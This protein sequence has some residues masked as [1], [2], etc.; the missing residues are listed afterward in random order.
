MSFIFK[1]SRLIAGII[2]ASMLFSSV[3]TAT[4]LA[5]NDENDDVDVIGTSSFEVVVDEDLEPSESEETVIDENV[6]SIPSDETE[7]TEVVV[8]P[9]EE[10][11]IET[12]E[13]TEPTEETTVEEPTTE[14]TTVVE[15]TS[16]TTVE[17][18]EETTETSV[19]PTETS[20]P[21]APS[22]FDLVKCVTMDQFVDMLKDLSD[23]RRVIVE[24][25]D[26]IEVE[27]ASALYFEGVYV[28][29]FTDE[30]SY[31]DAIAYFEA[32]G[33]TYA[34][35]G[36]MTVNGNVSYNAFKA[37]N[38]NGKKVAIIDTGS[39]N[40]NEY[41]SVIG[42][43]TSDDNGHGTAMSN[44]VAES[45]AY[46]ISIKALGSNGKGQVSD[47][48]VAL[49]LAKDLGVDYVLLSM[50]LRDLGNYDA[51]KSIVS[52]IIANGTTVVA[53]AGNNNRDASLYIPANISGV[54]TVG[55][56]NEDLTKN[57]YS[58]YGSVVDF[59][60]VASSTSEAAA[61]YIALEGTDAVYTEYKTEADITPTPETTVTPIP[62]G[63]D[64]ITFSDGTVLREIKTDE[65]YTYEVISMGSEFETTAL[66]V[67]KLGPGGLAGYENEWNK[68]VT[69]PSNVT[70]G[71][72]G[73]GTDTGTATMNHVSGGLGYASN[74]RS[75]S[76]SAYKLDSFIT[77]WLY[78]E[79]TCHRVSSSD[80]DIYKSQH[81]FSISDGAAV[82]YTANWTVS[83]S[84]NTTTITWT[85]YFYTSDTLST[86]NWTRVP[87]MG[88][89]PG[90]N[91]PNS[92]S[93]RYSVYG[94]TS[95]VPGN[96]NIRSVKFT[97]RGPGIDGEI[98]LFTDTYNA[99]TSTYTFNNAKKQQVLDA[100]SSR[101]RSAANIGEYTG[102]K[103]YVL[104]AVTSSGDWYI[105]DGLDGFI[106]SVYVY[107]HYWHTNQ[108]QVYIGAIYSDITRAPVTGDMMSITVTG[109]NGEA[110]SGCNFEL[111]SGYGTGRT[112]SGNGV[113]YPKDAT[114][115]G[116]KYTFSGSD[117][118]L[119]WYYLSDTSGKVTDTYWICLFDNGGSTAW[120]S[121]YKNGY[122]DKDIVSQGA[123][124]PYTYNAS[125]TYINATAASARSTT[126]HDVTL[127]G[128][129][130]SNI[131]FC[132]ERNMPFTNTTLS[133]YTWTNYYNSNATNATLASILGVNSANISAIDF[134]K[135][136]YAYSGNWQNT[137]GAIGSVSKPNRTFSQDE[138]QNYVW[139][140][141]NN[142]KTSGYYTIPT[143]ETKENNKGTTA[144]PFTLKYG[145]TTVTNSTPVEFN[146][147]QSGDTILRITTGNSNFNSNNYMVYTS[148]NGSTNNNITA[149]IDGANRIVITIP[150]NT[151]LDEI[152]GTTINIASK[153]YI[154]TNGSPATAQEY[155]AISYASNST[156][157]NR[158]TAYY[159]RELNGYNTSYSF[160]LN[161]NSHLQAIKASS[162]T[163]MSNTGRCYDFAGTVYT[164]YGSYN[165]ALNRTGGL[166]TLEF[167]SDGTMK[168]DAK[169][170]TQ[171]NR[172]YYLRERT[173]GSGYLI[174][175]HIY[176][177]NIGANPASNMV[178]NQYD[179]NR[180]MTKSNWATLV[181]E[182]GLYTITL[183]DTPTNDP[184]NISFRK[185]DENGQIV[186]TNPYQGARFYIEYYDEDIA[187][188]T[189][190]G[191]RTPR[192]KL[193]FTVNASSININ[194][195]F[196]KNSCTLV[197]G[198]NVFSNLNG[199]DLPLGTY[200]IYE[201]SA[202]T[203]YEVSNQ[204]LRYRIYQPSN[205]AMA[206]TVNTIEGT[207][208]ART[209]W[210]LSGDSAT[211]REAPVI[212]YFRLN[213]SM[214]D[215]NILE[216][217]VSKFNYEL[218]NKDTG[219]LIATGV[220][221]ETI[222][223][224]PNPNGTV[225]WQ[226]KQHIKDINTFDDLYNTW[227]S[228]IQLA[229]YN[230]NGSKINYEVREIIPAGSLNYANHSNIQYKYTTPTG[231]TRV[232]DTLFTLTVQMNENSTASAPY[233]ENMENNVEYSGFAISKSIPDQ[234]AFDKRTV[235][236]NVYEVSS[237]TLIATG[238]TDA[239]GNVTFTRT[240]ST[241]LG[242]T[243]GADS[244]V[245]SLNGINFLPYGTYRIE[246]YWDKHYLNTLDSDTLE[247]I[248]ILDQNLSA[249]WT[250][251]EDAT[252]VYYSFDIT[253]NTDKHIEPAGDITGKTEVVNEEISGWFKLQKQTQDVGDNA[254][255]YFEI[256]YINPDNGSKLLVA[257][258]TATTTNAAGTFT[259]VFTDY[260]G[261]KRANNTEILLPKGQYEIREIEPKTYYVRRDGS[262]SE[263]A[264]TYV[265]PKSGN[266]NWNIAWKDTAHTEVN[267]FYRNVNI[268]NEEVTVLTATA[269]NA[270]VEAQLSIYKEYTASVE[271]VPEVDFEFEIYYRGNGTSAQ[272]VGNFD[273]K[274][275]VEK[276]TVNCTDGSGASD[277]V[278][279][280]PEG[281]YEI[282][283]V[284]ATNWTIGWRGKGEVT[285]NNTK[286][287][288]VTSNGRTV[289]HPQFD[290]R[291]NNFGFYIKDAVVANNTVSVQIEI[292]KL[293]RWTH[294]VVRTA[295]LHPENIH[296][297]FALYNDG[298]NNEI[299]DADEM[300][301]YIASEDANE[302]G[303]VVFKNVSFGHYIIRETKTINGY[304]LTAV[305]IPVAVLTPDNIVFGEATPDTTPRNQ[306]Y[307]VPVEITKLDG[308]TN[309]PLSGAEF[310]IYVD[311]NE[312][313]KY[314]AGTDVRATA[315]VDENNDG[316][317]DQNEITTCV[318]TED[319]AKKGTYRSNGQ[320]HFND[321]YPEFGNQYILREVNAPANYFFVDPDT[322]DYTGENTEI[323]FV[324][325]AADTTAANFKVVPVEKTIKNVTG[326]V[327][328]YKKTEDGSFLSGCVFKV[329]T[330]EACTNEFATL[331]EDATNKCYYYKG[332]GLNTY[333]LKEVSVPD[334]YET[335]P[336][337][338]EF[339]VTTDDIH[340]VVDNLE[341]RVLNQYNTTDTNVFVNLDTVIKTTLVDDQ[342]KDHIATVADTIK[343]VD[344]I[345]YKGLHVGEEYEVTGYLYDTK[346]G[347]KYTDAEGNE[348]TATRTF[349][350][351]T[352]MG[353]VDLEFTFTYKYDVV[354]VVAYEYVYREGKLVGTHADLNDKFQQVKFPSIHTT[355]LDE[356]TNEHVGQQ[357]EEITLVDT[358]TYENLLLGYTY[359]MVGKLMNSDTQTALLDDEGNE[360]IATTEFTPEEENGTVDVVFTF[361]VPATLLAGTTTVAFESL[362]FTNTEV[363]DVTICTHNDFTDL[364]QTVDVPNLKTTFYDIML[365]GD[366]DH[367]IARN[368]ENVTLVDKVEYDHITV[369]L[370][371]TVFGTVMVKETGEPLRDAEGN[372]ITASTTFTPE[373]SSGYVNVVFE[374]IDTTQLADKTLVAFETLE[375]KGINIV[376]HADLDDN[377]QTVHIPEI[378]TTA[379]SE[380]TNEHVAPVTGTTTIVDTVAYSNLVV[381][382]EYMVTGT[383]VNQETGETLLDADGDPVTGFTVFTAETEDGT[384]DVLF[385]VDSSVLAG[386]TYVVFEDLYRNTVKI[387]VHADIEDES[388]TIDFPNIKTTFYCVDFTDINEDSENIGRV[389]DKVTLADK[390]KYDHLTPGLEYTVSGVVMDKATGEPILINGEQVVSST[391]FV[392]TEKSGIAI[393]IFEDIDTSALRG[394]TLV[395][396]E[397]LSIGDV[398]L[399]IHADIDDNAQTVKFP[400]LQTTLVGEDNVVRVDEEVTLIDTVHYSNL[401]VG[402]E[403]TVD[404]ILMDKATEK[405]LKDAN[406]EVVTG[407]TTFTA[408]AE[409]GDVEVIFTF[410]SS[411]LRGQ[412]TVAFETLKFQNIE[413]VVHADINDEGQTVVFPDVKTF[414]IDTATQDKMVKLGEK[415][416]LTDTVSYENLT[417]GK[418]YTLEGGL[419]ITD[420]TYLDG[421]VDYKTTKTFV[422]AEPNGTVDMIFEVDST[423]LIG[424]AIVAFET[425]SYNGKIVVAHT[426]MLDLDQTVYVADIHT[427]AA[428]KVDGDNIIDG[429]STDQT[430]VDTV[431]YENLVPGKTYTVT[432]K[433]VVKKDG[434]VEYAT[435]VLGNIIEA[436]TEFTPT[437]PNGTVEVV[438]EHINAAKYAGKKL[439]AFE[440]VSYEGVEL[441]THADIE[442]K[443][444]TITVSLVLHI[445]IAKADKD[446]VA[447]FLKDAEI[448]IFYAELDE[449][450]E[451][452]KDEDGNIIYKVAK[453]V[454]GADCVGMTD[455]NGNVDFS[456][457]LDRD[458]IK[459][460]AKETKAP[461]GYN[462][463]DDYFEVVPDESREDLGTC[464]ININILDAIIIIPPKTG[465]NMN[466]ALISVLA[467]LSV[468][469]IIG[470]VVFLKKKATPLANTEIE[471]MVESTDASDETSD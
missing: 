383:M 392:P 178:V 238:T 326:T 31:N 59:Y 114:Y 426:D 300:E 440:T 242:I 145:N 100:A 336:T 225:L 5:N 36:S 71:N 223:G 409:E 199:T 305:D 298:N 84:G 406:G 81:A 212:G 345:E 12:S 104:D 33:I 295:S 400:D 25:E 171:F 369:G 456:V 129:T 343:L 351:E 304:Y 250:R 465:D 396:F 310:E 399:V 154:N 108:S 424:K 206:D 230:A 308:E 330:D 16:E 279:R 18:S 138:L 457:V 429:T 49:Q 65:G 93:N 322:G 428:D 130:A 303:I 23:S 361:K 183:S 152:R 163:S 109:K 79:C 249:G 37:K 162:N 135:I 370:T 381:G 365:D 88:S 239:N 97:L 334:N 77:N 123:A 66:G 275:L 286:V 415:I 287:V 434:E 76:S 358:V 85:V 327:T 111:R 161:T 55:A 451:L 10:P 52:D 372:V 13:V 99:N 186:N 35:D 318:I 447:Y 407:T 236:W 166:W 232:S 160:K 471:P 376:I 233:T 51:F 462:I 127:N 29:S 11:P 323:V 203:G 296:L 120:K 356:I 452:I 350:P 269:T 38:A 207:N 231:W 467:A 246:E 221:T 278:T 73:S 234:D 404:G 417:P 165:D 219:D 136:L 146:M 403:Y 261:T 309:E 68:K 187:L 337:A 453:D 188:T 348:V 195:S 319:P 379:L 7:P 153:V 328:V 353:S 395:A 168:G 244:H 80:D 164:I 20:E 54:V 347:E 87:A 46:I 313:G 414:L 314:D 285:G 438:F 284:N 103:D 357:R 385:E 41:Y 412:T 137:T 209:D 116:G 70:P 144:F 27:N 306:P 458:D 282:R 82:N 431:Y 121:I 418:T 271:L 101:A 329:Y 213:K 464:L 316:L 175:N 443:E 333:Y 374:N 382:K 190:I 325:D 248:E 240:D 272:N 439:V 397:T 124:T 2:S 427:T 317:V 34:V 181:P 185:V 454:N 202:P 371:Y 24:T 341:W 131:T 254:P 410:N 222:N 277:P 441:A 420:M 75:N 167:N 58:N 198:T 241:G 270:R 43:N 433:L 297:T 194:L 229:V 402:K 338:Y 368:G 245:T 243:T 147:M 344:T 235:K 210:T 176:E 274:Y 28:I 247:K 112:P 437:T 26:E 170:I 446:N 115:S 301:Q 9:S 391:T 17:P 461:E 48:Y 21:E 408:E 89:N 416:T 39:N 419:R 293:D 260:N 6:T 157:Q 435:D 200:R 265:I 389:N 423:T 290:D 266:T 378:H 179:L 61:K 191:N 15:T 3:P 148:Y 291:I 253:L 1:K 387:E 324:V 64:I 307:T 158:I 196:I 60:V 321:G 469:G 299:L 311:V 110:I 363:T 312:N 450:G 332:L 273:A 32:N 362:L 107:D 50:S 69:W 444:Q 373:T 289:R 172:T 47:V 436:S 237:N 117:Y 255:V 106:K 45:G 78:A 470:C 214:E 30:A 57:E 268:E 335:D 8:E 367:G 92:R 364:N 133:G 251:R 141:M 388:Q 340:P 259:A 197:S 422:P 398:D 460:F 44:I 411:L 14:T 95:S 151:S 177:L 360:I 149:S 288:N 252:K 320:L 204:V 349:T 126:R 224:T 425:I 180:N 132:I 150:S 257:K 262:M 401:V 264:Y 263:F 215:Q 280:L 292:T 413:V 227:T 96:S 281:W 352:S 74:I 448:T 174:D 377:N 339:R 276:V 63:S 182:E 4:L 342:T 226:Y 354:T 302:D 189:D 315:W 193:S 256:Y 90:S 468:I 201:Y 220:I 430:V 421:D 67:P 139:W 217:P 173:A 155:Y 205:G 455:E 463:C 184:L 19:E 355:L 331:I 384:V 143:Y 86:R 53:S 98:T 156:Q 218:Y 119:G 390:V 91:Y 294:A 169:T 105:D 375:F 83:K 359:K 72:A 122:A 62:S 42:D 283:E 128:S 258:A 134:C 56:L 118:P 466:L 449:A 393:V 228:R 94:T 142:A 22:T 366:E 40:A 405:P 432:G 216:S 442:D 159:T 102:N 113:V 208:S 459:Y 125:A 445:Q 267:Y 380:E 386:T 211:L 192:T 346:T 140:V 394:K